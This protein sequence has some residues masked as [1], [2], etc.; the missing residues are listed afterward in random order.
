LIQT[1]IFDCCHSASGARGE[2]LIRAEAF[3][4]SLP[5]GV[6]TAYFKMLH[7]TVPPTFPNQHLF[8]HV[9]LAACG[10]DEFAAEVHNK[11]KFTTTLLDA[12]DEPGVDELTY[13]QFMNRLKPI[14]G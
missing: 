8:S 9:L 13:A 7:E 3:H 11:G 5:D 10:A 1:V 6:D 4:G 14:P 12:L 2:E